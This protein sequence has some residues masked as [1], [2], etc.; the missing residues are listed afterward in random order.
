MLMV[1]S[2]F[3]WKVEEK[4]PGVQDGISN[5]GPVFVFFDDFQK[6]PKLKSRDFDVAGSHLFFHKFLLRNDAL[7]DFG[8]SWLILIILS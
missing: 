8:Y 1:H 6:I 3:E 2:V 5:R 7:E 4:S